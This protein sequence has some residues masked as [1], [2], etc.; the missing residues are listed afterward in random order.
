[1]LWIISGVAA[2]IIV[3][4]LRNK[5]SLLKSLIG[6]VIAVI[7]QFLYD[8]NS[9]KLDLYKFH[10][11][12][13]PLTDNIDFFYTFGIV[14]AMG[15]FFCYYLP[16]KPFLKIMHALVFAVLFFALEEVMEHAGYFTSVHWNYLAS[17][18]INYFSLSTL[19]LIAEDFGLRGRRRRW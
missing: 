18:F 13:V 7:F 9:V 17:F 14:F 19:A 11:S 8:V 3:L 12:L 6:G 4:L 10:N 15:T 16:H 1:M 2:W 5:R